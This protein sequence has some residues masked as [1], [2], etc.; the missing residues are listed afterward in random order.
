[1]L[2]QIS[3]WSYQ[4]SIWNLSCFI[5]DIYDS[6]ICCR[7]S[8]FEYDV[9]KSTPFMY[10]ITGHNSYNH[11]LMR[12]FGHDIKVKSRVSNLMLLSICIYLVYSS[13][14]IMASYC[15]YWLLLILLVVCTKCH[16]LTS[17]VIYHKHVQFELNST[18]HPVLLGIYSTDI[19][20]NWTKCVVIGDYLYTQVL[21]NVKAMF[22]WSTSLIL[23]FYVVVNWT[24]MSMSVF[25]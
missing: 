24:R 9:R 18:V 15:V 23:S 19:S 1:M 8:D 2:N 17:L 3:L 16:I 14:V 7:A 10:V 5:N 12:M 13:V 4:R 11:Q 25:K 20:S 22:V 21:S 6:F